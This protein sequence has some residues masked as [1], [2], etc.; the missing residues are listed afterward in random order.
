MNRGL[1]GR[2]NVGSLP[3]AWSMA[4]SGAGAEM[5]ALMFFFPLFFFF[6]RHLFPFLKEGF[7][8]FLL[9][10]IPFQKTFLFFLGHVFDALLHH[11]VVFLFEVFMA[12]VIR[13]FGDFFPLGFFLGLAF[14][15]SLFFRV[16][17]VFHAF[18][19]NAV[20]ELLGS[21][22]PFPV[23]HVLPVGKELFLFFSQLLTLIRGQLAGL[24]RTFTVGAVV[25]MESVAVGAVVLM[26]SVA[27]RTGAARMF[28]ETV[29]M[30]A[31]TVMGTVELT[32]ARAGP[33][34]AVFVHMEGRA[35]FFQTRRLL[36][37]FI[38]VIQ[39]LLL[40]CGVFRFGSGECGACQYG[41]QYAC[42]K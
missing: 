33:A 12:L 15:K 36:F 41:C 26:E 35:A 5:T 6:R 38:V 30:R 39:T 31:G 25:L 2:G 27:V 29:V 8:P 3:V 10:F 37:N 24:V 21:F 13:H 22:A 9:A 20:D 19:V 40:G 34:V 4:V 14:F 11:F 28:V 1:H 16:G 7:H 17:H 18:F 42:G 23:G 32:M